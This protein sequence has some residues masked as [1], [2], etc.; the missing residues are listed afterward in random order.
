MQNGSPII[1]I[2]GLMS[3]ELLALAIVLF[4]FVYIKK[5]NLNKW[6]HFGAA[7]IMGFLML[8]MLATFIGAIC[9]CC[10]HRGHEREERMIIRGEMGEGMEMMGRHHHMMSMMR[11]GECEGG[12]CSEMRGGECREGMECEGMEKCD[13][14][15]CKN[16]EK[17]E[18]DKKGEHCDMSKGKCDMGGM[19][20]IKK[21]SVADKKGPKK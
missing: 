4:I 5:Q 17:C 15:C 11:G 20:V 16:G 21:D 7:A 19:K 12:E 9:H 2:L 13:M 6:F 10:G 3:F 1:H 18:M 8:I 14:P